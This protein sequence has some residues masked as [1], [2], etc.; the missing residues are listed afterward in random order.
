MKTINYQTISNTL[1]NGELKHIIGGGN[2]LVTEGG[3]ANGGGKCE[4]TCLDGSGTFSGDD[5]VD[6]AYKNCSC[7][8]CGYKCSDSCF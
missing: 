7:P 6:I 3:G 1:S 5:C 4:A 2:G 8:Q